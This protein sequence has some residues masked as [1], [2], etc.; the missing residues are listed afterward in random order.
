M[1]QQHQLHLCCSGLTA[2]AAAFCAT[3]LRQFHN[4]VAAAQV[5]PAHPLLGTIKVAWGRQRHG[6]LYLYTA[7]LYAGQTLEDLLDRLG[8]QEWEATSVQVRA[9]WVKCLL[10]Q[11]LTATKALPGMVSEACTAGPA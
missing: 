9:R 6:R 8:Q 5:V 2:S 10:A 7:S 11:G 1:E 3:L 4:E